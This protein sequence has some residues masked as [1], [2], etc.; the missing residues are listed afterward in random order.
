[1]SKEQDI[2]KWWESYSE[3]EAKRRK[4]EWLGEHNKSRKSN[5]V[6]DKLTDKEFNTVLAGT[7]SDI[8]F[9]TT[10]GYMHVTKAERETWNKVTYE[11]L[12]KVATREADGIMSKE[13]KIKLDNIQEG[14]NNYTH[15]KYTPVNTYKYK[16]V[17]EYG[18]IYG[19]SNPEILPVTVDSVDTLNGKPLEWFAKN[20]NQVFNNIT[21]PDIDVSKAKDN[22]AVNYTT[23]KNYA[24]DSV[25]QFSESNTNL[26]TKK[27]WYNTKTGASYYFNNGTWKQ[28]TS[29]DNPVTY[30]TDTGKIDNRYIPATG[31][32]IGYIATIYGNVV[33]KNFLLLDGST[34]NKND[35]PAL[36]DRV[37]RYCK[38]IQESE[39]NANN[40]T[41]YFS[42]VSSDDNLI[43]LPNFYNLHL[44][45][46]SDLS[47]HGNISKARRANIF[48]TLPIT[49][50]STY[51]ADF[52]RGLYNKYP[53]IKYTYKNVPDYSYPYYNQ[54]AETGPIGYTYTNNNRESLN[55]Y[56]KPIV[57]ETSDGFSS[58]SVTVLYCIKAK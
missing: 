36:W 45:P 19:Y 21:V 52:N 7:L 40:K 37:S 41:M 54:R 17:D 16:K 22:A 48:G 12:T 33:P 23:M 11:A 32:P 9:H 43:R 2:I 14:A 47:R 53:L 20:N 1:M 15:P 10:D 29:P 18:H 28:L 13:D 25:I 35:Y 56:Y 27:L 51:E 44:R 50:F 6:V 5:I 31:F 49:T 39:F 24:L 4:E 3:D 58:R 57:N 34:I 26:N 38:I 46:T 42:Y 8:N 55:F 30:N